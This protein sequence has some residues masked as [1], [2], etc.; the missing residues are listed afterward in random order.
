MFCCHEGAEEFSQGFNPGNHQASRF[1]LSGQETTSRLTR[2]IK[3]VRSE[4][5]FKANRRG[6]AVPRVK[7]LG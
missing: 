3:C 4:S 5:P 1:A 2:A 7:T 6:G